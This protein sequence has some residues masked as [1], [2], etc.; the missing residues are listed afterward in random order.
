MSSLITE[1]YI[2][3]KLL[4]AYRPGVVASTDG[5]SGMDEEGSLKCAAVLMPLV[6]LEDN[7][8]LVFTRR[9]ETVEHHK[10]QVSFPGGGCEVNELTPE[11]T[12]LREASEEIGVKPE[13]VRLLGRLNDVIT[14][15]RY[16]VTPVVGVMP[17]PYRVRLEPAEVERIFT[18]PLMWLADR[19]NWSEQPIKPDGAVHPF[20]LISYHRYDGEILWGISARITHHLLAVLDLQN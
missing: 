13:D 3:D 2:I 4:K 12:A 9:T 17:W 8:H 10:G 14:I 15:T 16:R 20:P 19:S 1:N 11:V 7:W 6:V 18:I 5:Y